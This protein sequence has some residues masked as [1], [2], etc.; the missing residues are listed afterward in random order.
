VDARRL[1]RTT[2]L[3]PRR[4]AQFREEPVQVRAHRPGGE[5]EPFADVAVREAVGG[6]LRD[7]EFLRAQLRPRLRNTMA[8][9]LTGRAQLAARAVGEA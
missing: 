4:D 3:H 2:K 9:T 1:E 6:Q 8:R 7:L 5:I